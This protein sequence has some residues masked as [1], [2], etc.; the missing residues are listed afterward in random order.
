MT[1]D[2]LISPF[3]LQQA[4]GYQAQ[5]A[6][7]PLRGR[8]DSLQLPPS[9]RATLP[10]SPGPN[11]LSAML[12][13]QQ[14]LS[15]SPSLKARRSF[16]DLSSFRSHADTQ[17]SHRPLE[18]TATGTA[19]LIYSSARA[20][21]PDLD[22]LLKAAE[23]VGENFATPRSVLASRHKVRPR[24][25]LSDYRAFEKQIN[26]SPEKKD[27][28]TIDLLNDGTSSGLLSPPTSSKIRDTQTFGPITQTH[29]RHSVGR[30]NERYAVLPH[31]RLATTAGDES[32]HLNPNPDPLE[33]GSLEPYKSGLGLTTYPP[34]ASPASI[35]SENHNSQRDADEWRRL[36]A[37]LQTIADEDRKRID[38][39]QDLLGT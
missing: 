15:L 3:F 14:T 19:Y 12:P 11:R 34:A 22:D 6:S 16:N 8:A 4:T 13:N 33:D 37:E 20:R 25:Q 2:P 31:H 9:G 38:S 1:P 28:T 18:P 17:V 27:F 36:K 29:S 10:P 30:K 5:A 32:P 26:S 39:L 35:L 7:P 23:Q 24:S 21:R